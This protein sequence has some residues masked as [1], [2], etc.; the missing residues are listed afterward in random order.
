[1][2]TAETIIGKA[3]DLVRAESTSDVPVIADSF[4]LTALTDGNMKWA[5]AFN[6]TGPIVF[7]RETGFDLAADTSLDG[8]ITTASTSVILTSATNFDSS[9]GIVVWDDN[10]PDVISYTGKSSN[11]LTGATGIAFAHE[12]SDP[13]QKLYALPST[14]GSFRESAIYGDGVLVNGVPLSFIGGPP[15]AGFFSMYDDGTTKFLWLARGS[16]GSASVLFNKASATIDS[17]D[18]TVDVPEEFQFFLIWHLVA[19]AFMGREN[20]ANAFLFA[21]N[22]SNKLLQEALRNRNIGK[23]IRPRSFGRLTKD[24]AIVGGNYVAFYG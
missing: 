8:A 5:R 17:T 9:G 3:R 10:M 14:F 20:N 1:M 4:M 18:D 6:K 19:F 22:E 23:K 2:P 24:Y 12:S 7:Q 16:T 13:V 11:T 15:T 21:Q